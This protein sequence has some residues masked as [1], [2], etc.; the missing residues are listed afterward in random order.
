LEQL[1]QQLEDL[2]ARLTDL[3][4]QVADG[5]FFSQSHDHTQKVL[6]DMAAAE[7]ALEQ[8]FARWEHLE[9]LKNGA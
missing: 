8:A 7:E 9:A 4:A 2:E 1:P 6:A 5:A 3:Q